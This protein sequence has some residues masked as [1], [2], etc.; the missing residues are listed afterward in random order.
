MSESNASS[1]PRMPFSSRSLPW[2]LLVILLGILFIL[3]IFAH[4][5][6]SGVGPQV[7]VP[8]F[9]DAHYLFPRPWTQEQSAPG[10]P[11]PAPIAVY[12]KNVVSQS[13]TAA[14]DNL[15]RVSFLLS[16][17]DDGVVTAVLKDESGGLR[18]A[19]IPLSSGGD[20][21]AYSIS[22]PAIAQAK[23]KRFT[24][25]LSAPHS[26]NE[27]PVILYTVGG[28]RLGDS[29]RL[30]EFIRPG[31][32]AL[33]AYSQGGPGLWWFD[34]LGEQLLPSMF[35]LRLQQYKPANFKGDFFT[36]LL[37]ITIGLSAVLLVVASPVLH[38]GEGAFRQRLARTFAWFLVLL[39]GSFLLW[40]VGSG[41]VQLFAG[42]RDVTAEYVA[43]DPPNPTG[44]R[45]R[46]VADLA[47][48]L[49]T[50]VREPDARL[51]NTESLLASPAIKVPGQSRIEYSL[52]IP[53]ESRLRFAPAPEGNGPVSF[54][55][56]VNGLP[57]FQ[58]EETT[59]DNARPGELTWRE[60]DLSPWAGQ[61]VVLSLETASQDEQAWGLWFMPQIVTDASWILPEPPDEILPVQV[62]FDETAE[63]LG[64]TV[65]ATSL[66][67]DGQLEVGLI[68]RPLQ[69]ND[70]YGK[71]FVHLLD[72]SGRLVS[73][74][75]APPL[76]GA[77]PFAIWQP[78]TIVQDVHL[79]PVDAD[80]L[81][82]G[83]FRLEI[84]VYDP[85]TL[86]R[87][88]AKE[89]NGSLI[90]QGNAVLELPSEVLP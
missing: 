64:A 25:T 11:E 13:F 33:T 1:S 18:R 7:Q 16:G 9:Y 77:Y 82:S 2:L 66:R 73:Q 53:P 69:E 71:V 88:S 48:D 70:R 46:I 44:A 50:A 17:P 14:A 51:F 8:M 74:H 81:T 39:T 83:P 22:F 32:L 67:S 60:L 55:V 68:W 30:N 79:L 31:N 20:R 61:G 40:Q 54:T 21:N 84:G 38:E 86:Q 59:R 49:W 27:Q 45:P 76:Q 35:R 3:G 10:V 75:D 41:R 26:D 24:L 85:D 65:D 36:W 23:G 43:G 78:G 80:A 58:T 56:T 37:V 4:W 19:E 5:R 42:S 72:G 62:R 6:S 47:S 90:E 52:I 15:S 28:D 89:A 12:G 57:V 63:L 87:W 34:A 29:L